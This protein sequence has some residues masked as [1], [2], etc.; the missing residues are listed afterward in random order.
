[1]KGEVKINE[2]EV[3]DHLGIHKEYQEYCKGKKSYD[4]QTFDMWLLETYPNM[5]FVKRVNL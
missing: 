2:G 5:L 1:M 4:R 3:M